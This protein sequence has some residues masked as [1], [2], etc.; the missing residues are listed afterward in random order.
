MTYQTLI[1]VH[2]SDLVFFPF[3]KKE[4]ENFVN[5]T[6]QTAALVNNFV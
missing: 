4:K 6:Y 5:D 1:I 3:Y 2:G